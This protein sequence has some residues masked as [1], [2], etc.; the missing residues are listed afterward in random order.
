[1]NFLGS[2][3][4]PRPEKQTKAEP[5]IEDITIKKTDGS[6]HKVKN[7]TVFKGGFVQK[8]PYLPWLVSGEVEEKYQK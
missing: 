1:M 3:G 6:S 8:K 4:E 2:D 7:W 5:G